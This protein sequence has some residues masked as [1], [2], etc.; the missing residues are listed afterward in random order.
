MAGIFSKLSSASSTGECRS[1]AAS[2]KSTELLINYAKTFRG[3]TALLPVQQTFPCFVT[4]GLRDNAD[5]R[6]Q[7]IEAHFLEFVALGRE[8]FPEAPGAWP[9]APVAADSLCYDG[10]GI[11]VQCGGQEYRLEI[12]HGRAVTVTSCAVTPDDFAKIT[13]P[14]MLAAYVEER[15]QTRM[16]LGLE[17]HVRH[18]QAKQVRQP[19]LTQLRAQ[20]PLYDRPNRLR[21]LAWLL[22]GGLLIYSGARWLGSGMKQGIVVNFF[23]WAM[24]VTGCVLIVRR[25]LDLI[26]PPSR[27]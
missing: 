9:R 13:D 24:I 3:F 18:M 12:D 25:G 8:Q 21:D 23:G 19:Q 6:P 26:F 27:L 4:L 20:K 17:M 1:S 16:P 14:E 7:G 5:A 2:M 22:V 11:I 15:P 10:R